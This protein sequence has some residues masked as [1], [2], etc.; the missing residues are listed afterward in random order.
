MKE[1]SQRKLLYVHDG[2]KFIDKN[3]IVYGPLKD[4]LLPLK[5]RYSYLAPSIKFAQRVV[6][7]N[8]EDKDKY[9]VLKDYGIDIVPIPEISSIKG[10]L[11]NRGKARAVLSEAIKECDMLILRNSTNA[12][13]AQKI[14]EKQGKPYIF[15]VVSCNWDALWNYSF[16]GKLYAPY[17]FLR[18][19]HNVA[20][21]KYAMYVTKEFLQRRYPNHHNNVGIS[22]VMID[23]VDTT[24]LEEKTKR[25]REQQPIILT[26]CAAIDVKY[27]GQEYI[28]RAMSRLK[29]KYDIEYHLAGKG[30]RQYLETVAKECGIE[31]KVVFEGL[32]SK[33]KVNELLD[34]TTIYCQPSK[35]EGLPRAVV[36]AMSRGCVCIGS[37]TGG[38]PELLDDKMIAGRGD[39]SGFT[40]LIDIILQNEELRVE[41]STKNFHKAL[42]YEANKL[43]KER[44]AF[45][46]KFINEN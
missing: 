16:T 36:E 24:L 11:S 7:L 6:P 1:Y 44:K 8:E 42:E 29:D 28:I 40:K 15:E 22:D 10:A 20:I 21:S 46:D 17:A 25:Y 19:K 30:D 31:D 41:Q 23:P 39:I 3:G 43:D 18:M 4:V 9:V 5:E 33:D 35:Q 38:I 13:L 37:R 12:A 45:Y 2:R 27:K 34:R 26:T 14:A 32:L